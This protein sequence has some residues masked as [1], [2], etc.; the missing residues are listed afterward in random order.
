MLGPISRV[1]AFSTYD[2]LA[3]VPVIGT[4]TSAVRLTQAIITIAYNCLKY[5]FSNM[6]RKTKLQENLKF[7]LLELKLGA[8]EIIPLIGNFFAYKFNK[9]IDN[10]RNNNTLGE[11]SA[12]LPNDKSITDQC[13]TKRLINE[14]KDALANFK[15]MNEAQLQRFHSIINK[16]TNAF[17]NEIYM[18]IGSILRLMKYRR[19]YFETFDFMP[20]EELRKTLSKIEARTHPSKVHT[21]AAALIRTKIQ[22]RETAIDKIAG[23]NA[24]TAIGGESMDAMEKRL[25]AKSDLTRLTG[26][27]QD[28]LNKISSL[29]GR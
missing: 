5:P 7:T 9:Q 26:L 18:Q 10:F 25:S 29:H 8:S 13:I 17:E 12:R 21:E 14:R 11:I 3:E 19:E 23:M 22:E 24:L 2:A 1:K 28:Q 4:M 27:E 6:E 20:I 16:P 15:Q